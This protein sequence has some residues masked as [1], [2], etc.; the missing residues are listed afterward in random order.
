MDYKLKYI[1][2]KEK[3]LKL[4]FQNGGNKLNSSGNSIKYT[5]TEYDTLPETEKKEFPFYCE[6]DK[7]NLC[8]IHTDNY[9]LCKTNP[10][11]CNTYSGEKQYATYDN[12]NGDRDTNIAAGKRQGYDLYTIATEADK[13]CSKLN[14][15][16]EQ[17]YGV[18]E[19]IPTK[20]KII[21]YNC[22]W[23]LKDGKDQ[24][25]TDFHRDHFDIRINDVGRILME[26]DADVV[27]L[28][29]CGDRTFNILKKIL[30]HKYPYSYENNT[31][32]FQKNNDG[33]RKRSIETVCFSKYKVK[34]FK[35]F[36][37]GGILRYNNSMLMLE[38]NNLVVFNVYLQA[39]GKNSLGQKD[40]WFNYSRCRYNEYL[41]IGKFMKDSGIQK[42]IVVLG[43][44]NTNLSG[45]LDEAPE[46]R[47]FKKLNLEDA[48]L[49]KYP[50]T[51]KDPGY[52]EDTQVNHMRWN[53]KFEEK[54]KRIDGIFHT[55]SVLKTN[56]IIVLGKDSVDDSKVPSDLMVKF[57]KY[58]IPDVADK[59]T[60]I[61]SNAGK[62]QI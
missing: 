42:P 51:I 17:D 14:L 45:T 32:K 37:V 31:D 41:S 53:V 35:L 28:Q 18:G 11:E 27:C 46:L 16:A 21:S 20:F 26:A 25:E 62:L 19:N 4:K 48:W 9:G 39:G 2:Y 12:I 24:T 57:E 5:K 23:N 36:G 55:K 58:R 10:D 7:P 3:Y 52:T 54:Q 43:D 6:N 13:D 30:E 40:L 60:K 47:A 33:T 59:S 8:T 56:E 49:N 50:N 44:F 34:S 61:R 22:W 38:F 1:K 29:E 15:D